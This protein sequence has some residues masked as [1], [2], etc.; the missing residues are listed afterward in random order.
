MFR[1]PVCG[2]TVDDKTSIK[3]DIRGRTYYFCSEYDR[4][5]FLDQTKV[6]YFSMEIGL[7]NDI[8]TYSG[9]LGVLAG[10]VVRTSAELRI[11][12]VAVSLVSKRGY[13]R[14]EITSDG[15]Q[16]DNHDEW[17]PSEF[18]KELP[19]QI[20]L[21]IQ[22]RKVNVKAWMYECQS[23]MEGMVPVL[24]LDTDVEGNAPEDRE[25]TSFL[26]GGDSAYRLKQEIVLGIGG[27]KMLEASGFKV[28]KYHMNEGHS[29]LLTL[30]LLKQNNMDS[31]KVKDLCVFTTH[32]PVEAAHDKFP[33]DLV[34][35]VL[36]DSFP[37]EKLKEFSD[38]DALNMTSLALNL[39]KYVNGVSEEHEAFSNRVYPSH[40]ISAITNGVHSHTWTSNSFRKLY[41]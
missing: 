38:Q 41:D 21:S 18:M 40:H 15:R 7:I 3:A 36:G 20:S 37:I 39:S 11:P 8:H 35:S 13:L 26:Y 34:E 31:D 16:I 23:L 12:L 27:F 9:G 2:I 22:G 6:A 10:D 14:Q 5:V 29:G 28:R 1:D 32:T 17:A 33:Y 24:F 4:H 19:V 30:E 25:L